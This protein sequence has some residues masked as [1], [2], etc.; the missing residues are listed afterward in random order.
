[1]KCLLCSQELASEEQLK[2]HYSNFHKVDPFDHFF[3]KLF[4]PVNKIYKPGKC[5]HCQDFIPTT[6]F[7][8]IHDFLKHHE[9]GKLNQ[10]EEKPTD[11]TRRR[12]LQ[13]TKQASK[14]QLKNI[15]TIMP[16]KI[17]GN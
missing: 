12:N 6:K 11:I 13:A 16:L 4:K 2:E 7:R 1:M 10:F 15:K 8:V 17:L 5:L 9:D 3:Q 14:F